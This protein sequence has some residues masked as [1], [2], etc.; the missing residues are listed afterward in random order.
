MQKIAHPPSLDL[1]GG[2]ENESHYLGS[3]V[4]SGLTLR[5][6]SANSGTSSGTNFQFRQVSFDPR[7][8][9][10]FVKSKSFMYGRGPT[11]GKTAFEAVCRESVVAGSDIPTKALSILQRTVLPALPFINATRLETACL[12][13]GDCGP[14]PYALLAGII[15]HSSPYITEMRAIHKTVWSHALLALEDE[16]RQPRLQTLQLALLAFSARPI[17]T[18][19]AGQSDIGLARAIGA[20]HLLGLHMEPSN[21]DLPLWE[22]SVR[23][24]IWWTLLIHDK[25]RAVMYGR[26]SNLHRLY[27]N[28]VLPTVTDGDWGKYASPAVQLSLETFVATCRLTLIIEL[29]VETMGELSDWQNSIVVR[30]AVGSCMRTVNFVL[31]LSGADRESFWMPYSS[32]HISNSA[33]LLV[34]IAIQSKSTDADLVAE[35]IRSVILVTEGLLSMYQES[36]W[37][38]A[39]SALKWMTAILSAACHQLPELKESARAVARAL[40]IPMNSD[41]ISVEEAF[42]SSD[43]NFDPMAW[44]GNDVSWLSADIFNGIPGPESSIEGMQAPMF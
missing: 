18:E 37:D 7:Q 25:W 13:V 44:L 6:I 32:L 39:E 30:S 4:F 10:Y 40:D 42:S 22:K 23:K 15:A 35:S 19:N 16:Y 12:G 41:D 20:A 9:A 36:A 14:I 21:W 5:E 28:V 17:Y 38:V 26:P 3:G 43:L 11:T 29:M 27:H 1:E 34:R 31:A 2:D 33:C 24:R 8:P